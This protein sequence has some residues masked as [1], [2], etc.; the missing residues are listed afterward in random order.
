ML[1]VA[2]GTIVIIAVVIVAIYFTVSKPKKTVQ[3]E[4]PTECS[5]VDLCVLPNAVDDS[6]FVTESNMNEDS[7]RTVEDCNV[8]VEYYCSDDVSAPLP[9]QSEDQ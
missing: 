1:I 7:F 6:N 5:M 2:A 8:V 3:A 4:L 9:A